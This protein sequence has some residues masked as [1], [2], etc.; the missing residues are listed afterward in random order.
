MRPHSTKYWIDDYCRVCGQGNLIISKYVKSGRYVI[1]CDE[2]E[3]EWKHP[4]L[5]DSNRLPLH[6]GLPPHLSNSEHGEI[7][8]ATLE[9]IKVLGWDEYVT[10]NAIDYECV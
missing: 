8:N 1:M 2:C 10:G 5:G 4:D 7:K 3:A 9:E 6:P